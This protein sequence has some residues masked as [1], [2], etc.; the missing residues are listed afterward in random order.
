MIFILVALFLLIGI[1]S[2]LVTPW[3]SVSVLPIILFIWYRNGKRYMPVSLM[4]FTLGFLYGYF[5]PKGNNINGDLIGIVIKSEDNYYL[6]KTIKGIF[7]VKD[8]ENDLGILSIIK[9]KCY[10]TELS[11]SHYESRFDF[12]EYLKGF[13]IFNSLT[14][15]SKKVILNNPINSSAI[16]NYAISYLNKNG[17]DIVSS[18]L[19]HDGLT[20]S[21]LNSINGLSLNN[22]LSV[23][24]F[25]LSFLMRIIHLFLNRHKHRRNLFIEAGIVFF[26]LFI[27]DF[28]ISI[29]RIFLL[30]VLKIPQKEGHS[31]FDFM[32]RLSIVLA[33]FLLSS[34]Y[35]IFSSSFIYSFPFLYF[36]AFFN[37]RRRNDKNP[38]PFFILITLF[39]L[40]YRLSSEY[41]LSLIGL[42]LSYPF[43]IYSHFLFLLSLALLIIPQIGYLLNPL[44]VGLVRLTNTIY[45]HDLFLISGKPKTIFALI[46]YSLLIFGYI[47]HKYGFRKA[48]RNTVILTLLITCVQFIPDIS[49]H[50]EVAFIDVNQGDATLISYKKSHILIDTGGNAYVD[51][52]NECLIPYFRKRKIQSLD[53]VFITHYDYDHYGALDGLKS[54]FKIESIYDYSSFNQSN[55]YTISVGGLEVR[56]LNSYYDE[57]TDSNDKSAVFFFTIR[58]TDFLIM[59]DAPKEI[60]NR[61]MKDN[62]N[63]EA[64]VIKIS[65][66]GSDTSSGKEFLKK[67]KPNLA[68]ISCGLKNSYGHPHKATLNTLD[69]LSIPYR[70][71]DL[72]GTI[73]YSL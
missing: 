22:L 14:I 47:L 51:V 45:K 31:R 35:T 72:E 53:A 62:E 57:Y 24:G 73:T 18:L 52:A 65:H 3:I 21:D 12:A 43:A 1:S 70:R 50:Y 56:N 58:N 15:T 5:F 39:Y 49:N 41:G 25:H 29:L 55:D 40:P 59:G 23:S 10:S 11:F 9:V 26:F 69:S 54:S 8:K 6:L 32:T 4:F 61:I 16:K 17:K 68:I 36:I 46:F 67:V 48:Y 64:D 33:I 7:Y 44:C 13:G 42:V 60:E 19:F 2:A 34:P 38:L 66:H 71:T 27:S 28:A 63:I 37:K 30:Y 20:D